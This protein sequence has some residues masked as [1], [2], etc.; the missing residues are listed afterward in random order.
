VPSSSAYPPITEWVLPQAAIDATLAAVVPAGRTGRES[1]VFWL[2]TREDTSVIRCVVHLH[3]PGVVETLGRW[4]V[5]PEAYGVVARL[6]REHEL[7]LLASAHTHGRGVRV[8]LS[9]TDRERGTRVP[10]ILAIVIG[11]DGRDS[12]PARWSWN[13]FADGAFRELNAQERAR[14]VTITEGPVARWR[15]SAVGAEPWRPP[16][17]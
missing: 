5:S 9:R 8:A 14:R 17:G 3:G 11:N 7:T 15:A 6:A 12:N 4:V 1:G 16:G 2:G 10:G 13:T